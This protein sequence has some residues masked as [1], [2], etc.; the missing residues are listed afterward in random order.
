MRL[1]L[2][3]GGEEEFHVL[4]R[5]INGLPYGGLQTIIFNQ[6][7]TTLPLTLPSRE[8]NKPLS[9]K[10]WFSL[11]NCTAKHIWKFIFVIYF[12]GYQKQPQEGRL[13]TNLLRWQ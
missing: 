11:S 10:N 9:S 1:G 7:Q 13:D 2:R 12:F 5:E 4:S 8:Q 3:R 6:T